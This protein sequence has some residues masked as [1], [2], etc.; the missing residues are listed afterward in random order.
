MESQGGEIAC[1]VSPSVEAQN[2]A[3]TITGSTLASYAQVQ[4]YAA[5]E[6]SN[7]GA[8]HARPRQ[9]QVSTATTSVS[10]TAKNIHARTVAEK[11]Y[12]CTGKE[13][14][15]AK[16]ARRPTKLEPTTLRQPW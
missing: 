1:Y 2:F 12:A 14:T 4:E 11:V 6:K 5:T 15:D 7:M 13:S 3:S 9:N 16:P 8:Q 10:T